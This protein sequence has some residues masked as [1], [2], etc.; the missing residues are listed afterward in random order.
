MKKKANQKL[1]ARMTESVCYVTSQLFSVLRSRIG[2]SSSS[3][4]VD[5]RASSTAQARRPRAEYDK[6]GAGASVDRG[7]RAALTLAHRSPRAS[8]PRSPRSHIIYDSIREL[9]ANSR[10]STN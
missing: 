6:W 10:F 7:Q 4:F 8:Q 5:S 2:R 1:N 3:R 9:E